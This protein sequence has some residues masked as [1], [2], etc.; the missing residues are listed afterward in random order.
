MKHAPKGQKPIAQGIALG[1][2]CDMKHALKGQKPIAQGIALGAQCNMK[3]ALKRQKTFLYYSF[4]LSGRR[5]LY[6]MPQGDALG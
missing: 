1:A 4:A 3:H 2:Q 6:A 5:M